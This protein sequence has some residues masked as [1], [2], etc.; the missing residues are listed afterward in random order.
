MIFAA[1]QIR[2]EA[3]GTGRLAGNGKEVLKRAEAAGVLTASERAAVAE[4][5]A[6]GAALHVSSEAQRKVTGLMYDEKYADWRARMKNEKTLQPIV[7]FVKL[8]DGH[9][10]A[11]HAAAGTM[12]GTTGQ[13]FPLPF[14][15]VPPP[16]AHTHTPL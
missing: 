16:R 14:M 1:R 7:N 4:L 10:K 15:Q 9:W 11:L 5:G 8:L 2:T 3:A 6:G 12:M 13:N